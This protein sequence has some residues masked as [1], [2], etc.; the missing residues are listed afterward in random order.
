MTYR[1]LPPIP[2]SIFITLAY[3]RLRRILPLATAHWLMDG[4]SAFA[5][6]LWPLLR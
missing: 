6:T 4:A 1:M 2:F 5:G 3:L